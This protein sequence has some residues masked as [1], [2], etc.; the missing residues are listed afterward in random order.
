M[1]RLWRFGALGGLLLA[2]L[3]VVPASAVQ[4][5]PTNVPAPSASTW[6]LNGTAT[7]PSA[8]VL[9]L[10]DATTQYEVGSAFYSTAVP[11]AGM[12]AQF[13]GFL[14]NG[15]GADGLTLTLAD[16][17]MSTPSALGSVG[18]G[19]GFAGVGGLAVSL[20]TY[21]NGAGDPSNNFVGIATT[22]VAGSV[23]HYVAT[24]ATVP[25][26]RNVVDHVEVI[27]TATSVVVKLNGSQV[28]N[29]VSIAVPTAV[30]V[31]FS[32]ASGGLTDLHSISNVNITAAGTGPPP[33]S[34]AVLGMY[35]SNDSRTNVNASQTGLTPTNAGSLHTLWTAPEGPASA[36]GNFNGASTQPVVVNGTVYWG[37][38]NGYEH[39]TNAATGVDLWRANLGVTDDPSCSPPGV[40]VSSTATIGMVGAKTEVFVGGGDA[41]FYALDA[42][43]GSVVWKTSLGASPAHFIWGSPTIV[44]GNVYIGVSSFGDCPLVHGGLAELDAGSGAL[45]NLFYTDQQS[46]NSTCLG[47]DVSTSPAY[48]PTDNSLYFSTGNASCTLPL[49]QSIVKVDATTL[50]LLDHWEVP[51]SQAIVDGDFLSTPTLFTGTI[52]GQA[53]PLVGEANKNGI[54]YA[55]KRSSLSAGPVWQTSLAKPA[56]C[57]ECNGQG[58]SIVPATYDGTS[59]YV[60]GGGVTIGGTAYNGSIAALDPSTGAFKWQDGEGGSVLVAATPGAGVLVVGDI[61]GVLHVVRADTGAQASS[62][63]LG[64]VTSP[65]FASAAVANGVVYQPT[66]AGT[67]V[68]LGP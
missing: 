60:G 6:T 36:Q 68:A 24:N 25:V 15:T 4:A 18:G 40:G 12:D 10:T 65:L 46:G 54:F 48:D 11:G 66:G 43:N 59:L 64:S 42:S 8:S 55:F 33:M 51:A 38:W 7:L 56:A 9:Q 14:G 44:N 13:D 20:D 22:G 67:L 17:T 63:V 45:R 41:N 34:V 1:R 19:E 28:L 58:S 23:L 29:D 57:P 5:T 39:A 61:S 31:G 52:A 16:A 2:S 27:T 37:D 47:A 32:G 30:Y 21:K 3:V 53:T 62:A 35:L 49:Q 26:L 50:N